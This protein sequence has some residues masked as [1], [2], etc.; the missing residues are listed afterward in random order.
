MHILQQYNASIKAT[1]MYHS[2]KISEGYHVL[3]TIPLSIPP[4]NSKNLCKK[5]QQSLN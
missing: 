1:R 3:T 2:V 5:V 4:I